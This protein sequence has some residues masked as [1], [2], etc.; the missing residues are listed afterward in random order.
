MTTLSTEPDSA[1][2]IRSVLVLAALVLL[3][4]I[5][6]G[7]AI[8]L[9]SLTSD[10]HTLS[11]GELT[12]GAQPPTGPDPVGTGTL[13]LLGVYAL[14]LA[15]LGALIALVGCGVQ[16]LAAFPRAVRQVSPRVA[17]GLVAVAVICLVEV[18][19]FLSPV[20]RALTA[21]YLD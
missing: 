3:P 14:F 6:Y 20:G 9:P 19:W 17:A 21:W 13:G 16:L 18:A 15:P 10:L 7:A 5:V 11:T 12:A 4:G 2:G 1:V 8:L